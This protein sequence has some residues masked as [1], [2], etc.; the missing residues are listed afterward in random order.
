[1]FAKIDR[2]KALLVCA[3][4]VPSPSLHVV[5]S[6]I[7]KYLFMADVPKD[8]EL[9]KLLLMPLTHYYSFIGLLCSFCK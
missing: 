8:I 4:A 6:M 1:M 7:M 9:H 2:V 5:V 3:H